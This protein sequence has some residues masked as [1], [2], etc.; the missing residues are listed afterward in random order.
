M[1]VYDVW[2][3]RYVELPDTPFQRWLERWH[4]CPQS[5]LWVGKRTPAQAW[6]ECPRWPWMIWALKRK[7]KD[8][9][10]PLWVHKIA[11]LPY[12]RDGADYLRKNFNYKGERINVR[13]RQP[14]R[15]SAKRSAPKRRKR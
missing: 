8:F 10:E 15:K 5:R 1:F 12:T 14:V 13:K 9:N 6:K 7:N 3:G 11:Q 4:A 2:T